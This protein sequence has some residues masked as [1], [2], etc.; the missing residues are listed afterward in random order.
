MGGFNEVTFLVKGD[1]V[2]TPPQARGRARTGCSGCR[3]PRAR[4]ASTPRRRRS[5]CCP[6]PRRS[7]SHIDPNDLRSTSTAR[8]GPGGQSVNTT[9]SAVRITHKPTGHRRGHAGREEPAPE[10]GQGHA[11]AAGPAAQARAGPPGGR[12]VRR[13]AR[14]GRRRRSLARRSAPTTSRRTGSPTT[15]S[16]S[17]STSSTRCCRA[18]STTSSTRS[19]PTSGPASCRRDESGVTGSRS[20]RSWRELLADD[21]AERARSP[22]R[23]PL[24]ASRRRSGS[25]APSWFL[26]LDER[27]RPPGAVAYLTRHGRAPAGGRAAAV[28]ARALGLPLA[29]PAGRPPGADPAARDRAGRRAGARAEAAPAGRAGA[30]A[31]RSVDLGT[32]SGAI[33][34]SLAAELGAEVWATDVSARRARRRPGQPGRSRAWAA[35]RVRLLKGSWW[36]AL[37]AE[38]RERIDVAVANPPYIGE[39]EILPPEVE[40]YEPRVA[41]RSATRARRDHRDCHR[42]GRMACSG[43]RAA[44]GAGAGPG[45]HGPRSCPAIGCRS[46]GHP[47]GRTRT[48]D[49]AL[50][51]QW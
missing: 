10:P 32:G 39:E 14:P 30:A 42:G 18:S 2:W 26:A 6:R 43:R 49:R 9:D 11:G 20:G 12:A 45:P 36:A 3:S 27:R 1:G 19:W 33:A 13:P 29:R 50:V 35:T 23:G 17:R 41:L 4:A 34:L 16:G 48:R 47:S 8:P 28:R 51:A 38:L 46:R 37:P 24:A 22:R 15:A 25:T 40:E 7:T 21:A 31:R 5:R 44:G